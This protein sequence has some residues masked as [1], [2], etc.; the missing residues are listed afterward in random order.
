MCICFPFFQFGGIW[1]DICN[2]SNFNPGALLHALLSGG[3]GESGVSGERG[4]EVR[5][6]TKARPTT[7]S[8]SGGRGTE[9]GDLCRAW[10]GDA[11]LAGDADRAGGTATCRVGSLAGAV[12]RGGATGAGRVG[13]AGR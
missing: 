12:R 8:G 4:I 11:E 3:S 10:T 5:N 13:R 2:A 1:I 9:V 6:S 7:R